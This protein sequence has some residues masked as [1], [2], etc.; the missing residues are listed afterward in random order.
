VTLGHILIAV[1][2]GVGM[3]A[4]LVAECRNERQIKRDEAEAKRLGIIGFR[5]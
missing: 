1:I 2:F 4:W 5:R 3:A